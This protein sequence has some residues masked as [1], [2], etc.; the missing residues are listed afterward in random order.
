ML[1]EEFLPSAI[2]LSLRQRAAAIDHYG[3]AGIGRGAGFREN[4]RIRSDDIFWLRVDNPVDLHWL[5]L[6]EHLRLELNRRLFMGL[7]EFECH[8]ARYAPGAF[9]R[10]HFDAFKGEGIRL[11]STVFYLNDNWLPGEGGELVVYD[12]DNGGHRIAPRGGSLVLFLSEEFA[13]EV[14]PTHRERFSITGW[15]RANMSTSER[16]DPPA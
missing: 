16:P 10:R 8:Y 2:W 12:R 15:Y 5:S 6:M 11:L 9:Y 3:T 13:H 4:S 7:F 1:I 14:R